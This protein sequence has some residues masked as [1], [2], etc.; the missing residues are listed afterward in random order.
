[1]SGKNI[2]TA[3]YWG[4]YLR[5]TSHLS[6]EQHGAYILLLAHYYCSMEAIPA[7]MKMIYRICRCS[8]K[9]EEKSTRFVL[10]TFFVLHEG[11]YYNSRAEKEL[12]RIVQLSKKR[13]DAVNNRY[14][15]KKIPH[16]TIVPTIV[17]EL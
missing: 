8:T 17:D 6:P 1:M 11:K 5:D 10:Q 2:W 7:D 12:D 4:D 16:L 13:R 15:K 14:G 9:N 3:F